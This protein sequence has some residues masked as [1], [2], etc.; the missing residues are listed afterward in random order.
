MK[1][2]ELTRKHDLRLRAAGYRDR[3]EGLPD[4]AQAWMDGYK[5]ALKAIRRALGK[6]GTTRSVRKLLQPMR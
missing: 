5:T 2:N 3:Q 6:S 4:V 1:K